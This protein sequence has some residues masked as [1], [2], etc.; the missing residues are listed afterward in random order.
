MT[1]TTK[2]LGHKEASSGRKMIA[3]GHKMVLSGRRLPCDHLGQHGF[4]HLWSWIHLKRG[5]LQ[6]PVHCPCKV[7]QKH[8]TAVTLKNLVLTKMVG[9]RSERK[10]K[11][12]LFNDASKAH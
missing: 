8:V 4:D 11:F 1:K 3:S 10:R 7:S 5:S 9:R 12:V 6:A 2:T